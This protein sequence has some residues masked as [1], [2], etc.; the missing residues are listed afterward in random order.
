MVLYKGGRYT[1]GTGIQASSD[2]DPTLPY[3]SEDRETVQTHP[4]L[5][6]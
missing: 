5:V 6:S 4:S 1:S 2:Q 3:S